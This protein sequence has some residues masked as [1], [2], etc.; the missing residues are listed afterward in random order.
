MS[1]KSYLKNQIRLVSLTNYDLFTDQEYDLY[2]QIVETKN[3]LNR[4]ANKD[5][6][7]DK[8]PW[9][10]QQ[11]KKAVS[12]LVSL[13]KKHA[14]TPR[15]VRLKS[16]LYSRNKDDPF[17]EAASWKNLKFSKK[18]TE[19]ASELSR[20][21]GLKHLDYT[22]DKIVI[23]W[24]SAD[25]LQ[26][27]VMDGFYFDVLD[28]HENIKKKHY[29]CFTA[30]A[31]QLRRDKVVFMSDDVW[32]KIHFRLE[33]GLTWERINELGGVNAS[34]YMAYIALS[35][36][37]SDEWT[38]FNIDWCIVVPEFKGEVT[39]RMLYIKSDYTVEDGVRTVEI[40]HTDGSG[41]ML[42]EISTSN[43]MIRGPWFKGLLSSFNYIKFCKVHNVD[44]VIEDAWGLKHNLE[45]ENIK[46]IFT[47]SQFK[48]WKYYS[49]WQEYKNCFKQCGA[50]FCKT[51]YEEDYVEET[52]TNYQ[53]LQTL[54]DFTDEEIQR[55][56][57]REHE[58]ILGL[59]KDKESMLQT[60]HANELSESPYKAALAIYPELL[61]EAYTRNQLKDIRKRMLYDA[62]SGKIK[63][64][65]KRLFAIP[66]FYAAC[67]HWFLKQDHPKGLLENGEIACKVFR[68]Q[69]KA[70]VLRSP[71]LY[72]EHAC[73]TIKNNDMISEWFYTNGVYT[74]CHDLISRILQF[75]VD[76]DEL[77]VVVDPLIVQIAER[78]IKKY[79]VIP[80]FYDAN[81]AAPEII[82]KEGQFHG[83]KRAHDC[84]GIG[85]ISNMLTRLWNRDKPDRLAA[86]WLTYFN[87]QVIDGAKTGAINTYENY[88]QVA[89]QIS[90]AVGGK[91]GRQPHFFQ[92]SRNGRKQE[93]GKPRKSYAKPN[94]STMNRICAA[95]DD[96]GNI[97][98]NYAGILRF[99][100]KMF[101]AEPCMWTRPEIPQLFCELDNINLSNVIEAQDS[102]YT[103]EREQI[104]GYELLAQMIAQ[105]MIETF[106]SLEISYPYI[107]KYLFAGENMDKVAHKQMFWRVY[108]DIALRNIKENLT[109]CDECPDC[110]ARVPAWDKNH[111]CSKTGKG[112]FECEDCNRLFERTNSKQCRCEDCQK[113]HREAMMKDY[114]S[115]RYKKQ[116]EEKKERITSL[117]SRFVKT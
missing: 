40:D 8:V 62:R 46:I 20:A 91:H 87:N 43:F 65:N 31:G 25:V 92:Y 21:M 73:R 57:H 2:M 61:R 78:N 81:T 59:T 103:T 10:K 50:K 102:P 108:G 107:V 111:I 42:P 113:K 95:F 19:F 30:S 54:S 44:A 66:D 28:E 60:L 11:K 82:S 14:G 27:L 56:V 67:E 34:K 16:V 55:F 112:F 13:V 77:N 71:H 106:G 115:K 94:E 85:E 51:H 109:S 80:L 88:P 105:E 33:C 38:G 9:L 89:R 17:P 104:A 24:K 22:L 3:E 116:K 114:Q 74:S 36:S 99:N 64:G 29:R 63:T 110:R 26:Q 32:N 48:M 97:D 72:C 45:K 98:L 39:D 18:I 96:I 7:N 41:M 35:S 70:D 6:T 117:V 47:T 1:E 68:L 15:T 90:K 12:D 58:R 4:L 69:G 83:L 101:L 23:K 52:Y 79:D 75:D 5:P 84:S 37:A 100:W 76:G 93:P 49:S 86:A 53:V